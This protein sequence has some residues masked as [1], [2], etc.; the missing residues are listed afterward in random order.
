[1][2]GGHFAIS[3][4]WFEEVGGSD[5]GLETYSHE[6]MELG[7]RVWMCGGRVEIIP[8]SRVGHVQRRHVAFTFPNGEWLDMTKSVS[9]FYKN[10]KACVLAGC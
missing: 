2:Y 5:P 4:R 9:Q 3:R 10:Q 7:L 1:M 6:H 8:C